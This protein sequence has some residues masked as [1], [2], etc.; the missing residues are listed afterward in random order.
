MRRA[1]DAAIDTARPAPSAVAWGNG[2][3]DVIWAG[4][5]GSGNKKGRLLFPFLQIF[6]RREICA[7]AHVDSNSVL[8]W[9]GSCVPRKWLI[10]SLIGYL[11]K[12]R[13]GLWK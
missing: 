6:R 1:V 5:G 7:R 8:S 10:H 11:G 13:R 2:L 12:W 9:N 3:K 4:A